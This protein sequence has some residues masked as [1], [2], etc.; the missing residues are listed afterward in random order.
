TDLVHLFL[1]EAD[2]LL[3]DEDAELAGLLEI[4]HGDEI[5]RGLDAVV[6]LRRHVGERR[7]EQRAAEAVANGI[8]L[9]L[10]GGA[11]DRVEGGEDALLHV[12]LE[13]QLGERL[14]RIDPGDHE[15]RVAVADAVADPAVIRAQVEDVELV[16]PRRYDQQWALEH[17]I[18]ERLVL[19]E[20]HHVVLVDDL[21]G[22]DADVAAEVEG[23]VVHHLDRQLALAALEVGEQ[24]VQAAQQVLAAGFRGLAQDLRIGEQEVARAHRVDELAGVEVDLLR[25]LRIDPID[26]A[27]DLLQVAGGQQ[28]ALLDEVEDLVFFPGVVSEPL[29]A[30]RF[31]YRL[32]LDAHHP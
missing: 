12:V 29:V 11:L 10:A 24:V 7:C 17:R 3:V 30:I 2:L 8:D 28:V 4:H 14:V 15:H 31:D 25:R 20:L 1:D 27:H 5:R 32:D 26:V 6:A 16:D 22:R 23:G 19:D 18:G 13:I 9:A 21:A